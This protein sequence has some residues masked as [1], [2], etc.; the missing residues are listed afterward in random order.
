MGSIPPIVIWGMAYYCFNHTTPIAGCFVVENP[1]QIDDLGVAP[2]FGHLQIG[3][4]KW[5]CPMDVNKKI[6]K[7]KKTQMLEAIEVG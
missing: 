3:R 4:W 1:T 5:E 7:Y 2:I 6:D